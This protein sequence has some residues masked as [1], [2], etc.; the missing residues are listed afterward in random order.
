MRI[1]NAPKKLYTRARHSA[2]YMV[3]PKKAFSKKRQKTV[4]FIFF[5]FENL[6]FWVLCVQIIEKYFLNYKLSEVLKK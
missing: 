5:F 1:P 6:I 4:F 2:R 3:A